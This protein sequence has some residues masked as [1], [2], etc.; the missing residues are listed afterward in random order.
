M[1]NCRQ[2]DAEFIISYKKAIK[3]SLDQKNGKNLQSSD[4][5]VKLNKFVR[6]LLH[7]YC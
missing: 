2:K 1:I 7:I 4:N 6:F 5:Q 3:I